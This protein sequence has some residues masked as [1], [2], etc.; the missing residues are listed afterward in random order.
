MRRTERQSRMKVLG[1]TSLFL[2]VRCDLYCHFLH[3]CML[4]TTPT[5]PLGDGR[6]TVYKKT[7]LGY[8][9]QITRTTG[10]NGFERGRSR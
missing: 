7:H 4:H 2:A 6:N 3:C 1:I 9:H 5:E 8:L 10:D